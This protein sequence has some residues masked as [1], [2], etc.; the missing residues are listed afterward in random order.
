M[1][2]YAVLIVIQ[3]NDRSQSHRVKLTVG[4]FDHKSA[5]LY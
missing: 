4:E 3:C 1:V 5:Q 2:L